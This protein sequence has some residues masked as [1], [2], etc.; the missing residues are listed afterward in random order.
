MQYFEDNPEAS[1]SAPPV[2][3]VSPVSPISPVSPAP[4]VAQT[5]FLDSIEDPEVKEWAATKKWKDP[6]AAVQTAYHLQKMVGVP[7]EEI[8]RLPK[9]GDTEGFRNFML[10]AGA[11]AEVSGYEIST[12]GIDSP[13]TGFID[14][15]KGAFL[16]ASVTKEQAKELNASY[17]EYAAKNKQL[18]QETIAVKEAAEDRDLK[19]LW[20]NGYEKQISLAQRGAATFGFTAPMIDALQASV[21]YKETLMFLNKIGNTVTESSFVDGKGSGFSANMTPAEA[22]TAWMNMIQDE[23]TMKA[24][25]DNTSPGH[26]AALEKKAQIF[27]IMHPEA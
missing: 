15:A 9:V 3:P 10:K 6:A 1:G 12:E 14:W 5:S 11:P 4:P 21:G 22:K 17:N 20:G 13:D 8:V 23:A 19:T 25:M 18:L 27:K 16:K 2:S 24:L 26:K 7:H